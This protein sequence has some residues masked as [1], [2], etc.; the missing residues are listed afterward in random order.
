VRRS[1][2]VYAPVVR[3]PWREADR[4][5]FHLPSVNC[6]AFLELAAAVGRPVGISNTEAADDRE[7][8]FGVGIR[9]VEKMHAA[10]YF[11]RA[12]QLA[13]WR[14]TV[15]DVRNLVMEAFLDAAD[16]GT[17][18]ADQR[19]PGP[20]AKTTLESFAEQVVC[21]RPA[22]GSLAEMNPKRA[23]DSTAPQARKAK[24]TSGVPLRLAHPVDRENYLSQSVH[25][26]TSEFQLWNTV[27][28]LNEVATDA[29]SARA[30]QTARASGFPTAAGPSSDSSRSGAGGEFFFTEFDG[31]TADRVGYHN[32]TAVVEPAC[33]RAVVYRNAG[34]WH[35]VRGFL[36]ASEFTFRCALVVW[37]KEV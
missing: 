10:D 23:R 17:A 27:L 2:D 13:A 36:A 7:M 29:T 9:N 3:P 5:V 33:G 8:H 11:V 19:S 16:D 31:E 28:F 37:L 32:V 14:A 30:S 4:G 12:D 26:D 34:N 6:S 25:E 22:A 1:S 35:G 18:T 21:R 20:S 24:R 15:R